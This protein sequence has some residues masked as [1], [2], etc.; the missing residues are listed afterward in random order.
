MDRKEDS[1]QSFLNLFEN[2]DWNGLQIYSP[3]HDVVNNEFEG[4]QI[5]N[6]FH[7]LFDNL[8]FI[9]ASLD[10]GDK[11]FA[12]YQIELNANKIGLI[13]R[14]MSLYSES[15]VSML[16]FDPIDEIVESRF[17]LADSFGDGLW[18]FAEDAWLIDLNNDNQPDVVKRKNEWWED[19]DG[20]AQTKTTF[21]TYLYHSGQFHTSETQIDTTKFEVYKWR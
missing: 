14:N 18:R 6:E 7:H 10:D 16:I 20:N 15:A 3:R 19:D 4:R 11:I 5:P 12:V 1:T 13:V 21:S 8:N 17:K 2:T 9:S